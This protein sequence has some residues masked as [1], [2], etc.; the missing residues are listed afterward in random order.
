MLLRCGGGRNGPH[1]RKAE[2]ARAVW[3]TVYGV[4]GLPCGVWCQ[5]RVA[6]RTLRCVCV[7]QLLISGDTVEIDLTSRLTD[8]VFA[9]M[10]KRRQRRR[11]KGGISRTPSR[12]V[13]TW[14]RR[15]KEMAR[16]MRSSDKIVETRLQTT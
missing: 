15:S 7:L 1:T 10:A 6:S 8:Q 16:L 2:R 4:W 5:L 9:S 3:C 14:S 11:R 13:G 12:V